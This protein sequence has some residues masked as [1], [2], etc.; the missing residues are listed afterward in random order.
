MQKKLSMGF[1]ALAREDHREREREREQLSSE[2]VCAFTVSV[3]EKALD[4]VSFSVCLSTMYL[5]S[6]FL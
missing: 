2:K 1:W 4:D 6:F 5:F 3:F